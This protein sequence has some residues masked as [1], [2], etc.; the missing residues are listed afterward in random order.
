[1]VSILYISIA[2]LAALCVWSVIRLRGLQRFI[3]TKC[4]IMEMILK[5]IDAYVLLIDEDFNVLTT[6][7]YSLTGTSAP[8]KLPK[9]GNLLHCKNGDDAGQCGMHALCAEC[10]VRAAIGTA[11]REQK[12]FTGLEAPMT[13]YTV[14]DSTKTIDCDVSVTGNYLDM[15]G[16]PNLLLTIHDITSQKQIQQE[17][18]AAR[19][20]AEKADR[21][22]TVFLTNTSHEFRTP[23]NAIIGFS[24]LLGGGNCSPE[25]NQEYIHILRTNC[26]ALLQM[27]DDLLDLAK[28]ET[29]TLRYDYAET[30]LYTFMKELEGRF[31]SKQPAD[32]R[33]RIDFQA[34]CFS[35]RFLTAPKRLEQVFSNFISNALKFT[36][37]GEIVFG[38]EKRG[39]ELYFYVRDTGCGIPEEMVGNL[40]RR[41]AKI[42]S[43]K[44]GMGVGLALCKSIVTAL[45]GRIGVESQAGNGSKF[46]FTLPYDPAADTSHRATGIEAAGKAG[47]DTAGR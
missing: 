47:S 46:W 28:I 8:E 14:A 16:M 23:L 19:I 35:C 22:K 42:G 33:V 29:G 25:E 38:F 20:R 3:S 17:L 37:E 40:F 41:F 12:G 10:P 27:V 39:N 45:G 15:D 31:R 11:F 7:F 43:H 30:E 1:M 4:S 24:E 5:N 18:E 6:N 2:L 26:N 44:Q 34:T 9:V 13:L 32:S 36:A 21:A